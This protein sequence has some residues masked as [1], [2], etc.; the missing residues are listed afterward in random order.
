MLGRLD[1]FS[2]KTR[3]PLAGSTWNSV[4]NQPVPSH[5]TQETADHMLS[6]GLPVPR[7]TIKKAAARLTPGNGLVGHCQAD[8]L[9][10]VE[11]LHDF[12]PPK[13]FRQRAEHRRSTP[14]VQRSEL[15]NQSPLSAVSRISTSPNFAVQCCT[16]PKKDLPNGKN[17]LPSLQTPS[18]TWPLLATALAVMRFGF[19]WI[20]SLGLD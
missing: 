6:S 5:T 8:R 13:R 12:N 10:G 20:Q 9:R 11:E 19:I 15:P 7:Q 1:F 4:Q 16:K 2:L 3:K 17:P 18:Q 14:S